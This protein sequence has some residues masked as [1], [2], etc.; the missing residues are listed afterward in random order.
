[1]IMKKG[2]ILE[3]GGKRGIYTAGVLDVFLDNGI[4]FDGVIGVSAGAIHGCSYVSE[5]MGRSIRY[6]LKYGE[7][8]RFMS[9]RSWM[10]TGNMVDVD[11]CYHELPEKLDVF[12]NKTF[13]ESKTDFY[14]VCSNIESGEP[15]YILCKDMFKD[16]DY[17]RASASMPFV[18]RVVEVDGKK[19]LDGGITDSIPLKAAFGMGYDRNV[20][21]ATRPKFY[22]KKPFLF[23]WLAKLWYKKY[24]LFVRAMLNRHF[25]YNN[26]LEIMAEKERHGQILVIRPSRYI[27]VSKMERNLTKVNELYD[28]GRKDAYDAL[29]RVRKFL[30]VK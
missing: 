9:Y 29:E 30:E 16:I 19:Y 12:D 28:L 15:E 18:S 26:M 8:Y 13:M 20:V 2:L 21:I 10:L 5:Q 4:F 6:N 7:D 1:M 25:V 11:F 24:P 14:V 22:K 27:K 3:G 23:G 17:L